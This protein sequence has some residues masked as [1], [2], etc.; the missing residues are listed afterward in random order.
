MPNHIYNRLTVVEGN[1]DLDIVKSFNDVVPMPQELKD[2]THGG[3][4]MELEQCLG[5]TKSFFGDRPTIKEVYSKND[6]EE[7]DKLISNYLKYGYT[8]WYDW[9]VENWGTK[10]DMYERECDKNILTFQTAWRTPVE[11]YEEFAKTLPEGV[12]IKVEY[13]SEDFGYHT[14]LIELSSEGVVEQEFAGRG[15][16]AYDLAVE[17]IGMQDE[18]KYIDGEWVWLDEIDEDEE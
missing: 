4:S 17:L 5:I 9:S 12:I 13:A 3:V 2:T 8:T 14:G 16:E 15:Y 6:K 11:W 18:V 7:V 10:W 1:Y